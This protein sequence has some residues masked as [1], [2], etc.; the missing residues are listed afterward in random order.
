LKMRIWAAALLAAA[1][2]ANAEAQDGL[3]GT[4]PRNNGSVLEVM[5]AN[6]CQEGWLSQILLDSRIRPSEYRRLPKG[7]QVRL[8][9]R[10]CM[11]VPPRA[12]REAT[13][14]FLRGPRT[15]TKTVP[16][17]SPAPNPGPDP[18][19]K[20]IDDLKEELRLLRLAKEPAQPATDEP[21][22]KSVEA[23]QM[24]P[25]P[26]E[27]NLLSAFLVGAILM[28]ALSYFLFYRW[29]STKAYAE[30]TRSV[31]FYKRYGFTLE[32]IQLVGNGKVPHYEVV[33]RC[34]DCGKLVV[35]DSEAELKRHAEVEHSKDRVQTPPVVP[36]SP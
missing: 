7:K 34:N 20:I 21:G 29:K 17:P 4:I 19:E 27:L 31:D 28:A 35:G 16:R 14:L 6:K 30:T 11:D 12:T 3:I 13:T 15:V 36:K 26:G 9:G 1:I 10:S 5:K 33:L 2:S 24:P 32:R 23:V 8:R 25:S 22:N 18:H